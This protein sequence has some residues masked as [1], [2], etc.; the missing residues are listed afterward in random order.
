MCFHTA[1]TFKTKKLEK[2]YGVKLSNEEVRSILDKQA[3]LIRGSLQSA[4][5]GIK[6]SIYFGVSRFIARIYNS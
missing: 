2:H 1:T 3:V 4:F 5:S 6:M